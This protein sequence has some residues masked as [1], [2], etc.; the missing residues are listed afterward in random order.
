MH[1]RR[2]SIPR[3]ELQMKEVNLCLNKWMHSVSKFYLDESSQA[4]FAE[5]VIFKK[6]FKYCH[7]SMSAFMHVSI[8]DLIGF[9]S[10]VTVVLKLLMNALR[11]SVTVWVTVDRVYH[12]ITSHHSSTYTQAHT[13]TSMCSA[14]RCIKLRKFSAFRIVIGTDS[15]GE[16]RVNAIVKPQSDWT[17]INQSIYWPTNRKRNPKS[18]FLP[19]NTSKGSAGLTI[20]RS[21]STASRA[22]RRPENAC[23]RRKCM[24]FRLR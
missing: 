7:E 14:K 19:P 18:R 17:N 13:H 6:I 10:I 12:H 24:H 9:L 22:A 2:Q 5:S 11:I 16:R 1:S 20:T 21:V 23:N 15:V 8:S 4:L 3:S